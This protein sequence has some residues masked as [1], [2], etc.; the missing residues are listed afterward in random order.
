MSPQQGP[1][2]SLEAAAS[3]FFHPSSPLRPPRWLAIR[4]LPLSSAGPAWFGPWVLLP[5]WLLFPPTRPSPYGRGVEA[6]SAVRS[7]PYQYPR[8]RRNRSPC[9]VARRAVRRTPLLSRQSSFVLLCS[10]FTFTVLLPA[11]L[12]LAC[13]IHSTSRCLTL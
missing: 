3:P 11:A 8:K 2:T 13:D 10:T 12:T 9:P 4:G 5:V 6:K 1:Q 7:P